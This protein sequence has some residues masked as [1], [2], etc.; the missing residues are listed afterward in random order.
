MWEVMDAPNSCLGT[1]S[2]DPE[3]EVTWPSSVPKVGLFA[4]FF[5]GICNPSFSQHFTTLDPCWGSM[6]ISHL[7]GT[8]TMNNN[9]YKLQITPDLNPRFVVE[10][11]EH[12][13]SYGQ[14]MAVVLIRPA[15]RA[16]V[17]AVS[18]Y[19]LASRPG[20]VDQGLDV[21]KR[22]HQNRWCWL[23]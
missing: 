8:P 14:M 21:Q 19:D 15:S 2:N 20:A 13:P 12:G 23:K 3:M 4:W 6:N 9:E 22:E 1:M 7:L 10:H 16:Q 11:I 5:E 17:L 18:S